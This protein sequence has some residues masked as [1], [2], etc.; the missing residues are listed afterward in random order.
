MFSQAVQ[1]GIS[2]I[3]PQKQQTGMC[4]FLS[5]LYKQHGY[6]IDYK[7]LIIWKAFQTAM[8]YQLFTTHKHKVTKSWKYSESVKQIHR[9]ARV[10]LY[11]QK[12]SMLL[13]RRELK[14]TKYVFIKNSSKSCHDAILFNKNHMSFWPFLKPHGKYFFQSV[15]SKQNLI[16]HYTFHQ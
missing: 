2:N 11:R 12:S 8:S 3:H 16:I 14:P 1:T 6:L 9:W 5:L 13:Y 7:I 10:Q 15:F 4:T